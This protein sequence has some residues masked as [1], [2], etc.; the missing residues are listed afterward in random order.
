MLD[1]QGV[2]DAQSA[3]LVGLLGAPAVLVLTYACGLFE[4]RQRAELVLA[5]GAP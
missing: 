4:T 2:D 5:G 1:A 3:E